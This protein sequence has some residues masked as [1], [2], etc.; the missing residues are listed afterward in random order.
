MSEDH[1][2]LPGLPRTSRDIKPEYTL[3]P[4]CDVGDA[5][6]VCR[7]GQPS[8]REAAA[9][10]TPNSRAN[11]ASTSATSSMGTEMVP[12]DE[13]FARASTS[14]SSAFKRA[15]STSQVAM[16]LCSPPNA[17]RLSTSHGRADNDEEDDDVQL[18]LSQELVDLMDAAPT[19][20]GT[21]AHSD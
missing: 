1:V 8:S 6:P 9:T 21:E 12:Y 15:L 18:R 7:P 13:E 10:S 5:E 14:Q 17:P 11:G 16:D 20:P 19:F 4:K 3:E 2:M